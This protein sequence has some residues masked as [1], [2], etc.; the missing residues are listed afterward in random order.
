MK[1]VLLLVLLLMC[2]CSS[3]V[4]EKRSVGLYLH[5]W[6]SGKE[7]SGTASLVGPN[8]LLTCAHV[9]D[10]GMAWDINGEPVFWIYGAMEPTE[11]GQCDLAVLQG[12]ITG[13]PLEIGT[14]LYEL[15][16]EIHTHDGIKTGSAE[17]FQVI[18]I[19]PDIEYGDSGSPILQNGK[20]VGVLWGMDL[21]DNSRGYFTVSPIVQDFLR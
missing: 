2:A 16:I 19:T 10:E 18:D 4:D 13:D 14:L 12:R 5:G 1:R 3:Q 21:D 6:G 20:L 11:L 8:R 17:G 15:P 7:I 9:Y